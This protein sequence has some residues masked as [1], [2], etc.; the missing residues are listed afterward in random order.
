MDQVGGGRQ[1]ADDQQQE[2]DVRVLEGRDQRVH[3]TWRVS[4]RLPSGGAGLLG[5]QGVEREPAP[6]LELIADRGH[7]VGRGEP[8]LQ[9]VGLADR[10]RAARGVGDVDEAHVDGAHRGRIV[11]EQPD[12][13][14]LGLEVGRHLLGPLP[15][16]PSCDVAVAQVEVPTHA[17]RP[18]VVQPGVATGPGP[19]HQEPAVAVAQ[20]EIRDDLLVRRVLLGVGAAQEPALAPDDRERVDEVRAAHAQP[21]VA[22]DQGVARY[23]QHLLVGAAHQPSPA[24][25]ALAVPRRARSASTSGPPS[26]SR[27]PIQASSVARYSRSSAATGAALPGA[28]VI[29]SASTTEPGSGGWLIAA[30]RRSWRAA[31][32]AT[33]T[34]PQASA[35][36]RT[37]SG[38]P[39]PTASV[40]T[41]GRPWNSD[42]SAAPNP[43]VSRPAIGCPPTN[44]IPAWSAARVTAR[45]V[46]ATSVTVAPA[47]SASPSSRPSRPA[48]ATQA[49]GGP[50]STTSDAPRSASSG[51]SAAT[52]T[53]PAATA[54]RGP[55]P[56]GVHAA[57]CAPAMDGA[58]RT[59][60]ATD[61]P[62]MP[63][64]RNATRIAG[65]SGRR[66]R[67]EALD[68]LGG[69]ARPH[70]PNRAALQ[71]APP[72]R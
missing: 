12:R 72:C 56:A 27:R 37:A 42:P 11:V 32:M 30:T 3:G 15:P 38:S 1:P 18:Q 14:V 26:A 45:L 24:S 69:P 59:A 19:S 57:S 64:P 21:A 35:S 43:V 7:L 31:S 25:R 8:A 54:S 36:R 70:R 10:H 33:A 23:D 22:R 28:R 9:L 5:G 13:R 63:R 55:W 16:Q 39:P 49:R 47:S 34:A 4:H 17:D 20:H 68:W 58:A 71:E 40:T 41:H 6:G 62:I 66:A 46:E 65:L 52:S 67:C 48:S 53:T 2:R 60:R 51:R 61:P 29:V 50:A 44:G